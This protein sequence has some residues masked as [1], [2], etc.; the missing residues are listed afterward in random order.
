MYHD[1]WRIFL[2][3]PWVGTGLGTLIDVYPRYASFFNGLTVDH[4]HNDY[5]ELVADTGVLGG[6][7]GVSFIILLFWRGFANLQFAGRAAPRAVTAG[8]LAAC[9][10]LLIHSLVD[11]NLHIPSNALV[12]LLLAGIATAKATEPEPLST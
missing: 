11:F 12:F 5:L 7:C 9:A 1:T 4:A 6:I 10:G 8:C 2:D 3:H